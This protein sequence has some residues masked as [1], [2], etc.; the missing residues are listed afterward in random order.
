MADTAGMGRDLQRAIKLAE[1]LPNKNALFTAR[2]NYASIYSRNDPQRQV[3]VFRDLLDLAGDPTLVH[4]YKLYERTAF[5]FRNPRP[6]ILFQLMQVNLLLADYANAGRFA[7]ILYDTVVRP[8]PAAPQAPFFTAELAIVKAYQGDYTA[9]R[10]FLEES[11]KYFRRP[12]EKIPYPS[13]FLAAGM[14]DEHDGKD[15]Q[16]LGNYRKAYEMGGME[17]L[18]LEPSELY[19]AHAL[20]RMNR[21]AE[22][23]QVL[24]QVRAKLP[25]RTYTAYGYYYYQ[26]YAGLLRAKGDYIGYGK[27]LQQYYSIKDSLTNLNHY[28]AIEEIE[29]RVRLRDKEQ[30]IVRLNEEQL[31]RARRQ[32]EERIYFS[33]LFGLLLFLMVLL[34]GYLRNRMAGMRKQHRIDVMQGAMDAEQRERHKIA[35]QLHDEVGGLLSLAALNLSSALEGNPLEKRSQQQLQKAR[36]VVQA[37]GTTVRELSHRLTPLIIEKYGF[38]HAVEDLVETVNLSG[39][40]RLQLVMVGFGEG[41]VVGGSLRNEVYRTVQELVQ[42]VVRHAQATEALLQLVEHPDRISVMIEDN[43]IGIGEGELGSGKGLDTIRKKI[44]YF[45]GYL[46]ISSQPGKGALIVI[47]LPVENT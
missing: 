47:E 2:Y 34:I 17:G 14:I 24:D 5:C 7:D 8:N 44:A 23:A 26:Q 6:S 33:V 41:S 39:K 37:V 15:E 9:A 10:Q 11:R 18:H 35:D 28:R 30:Q 13:Y 27:A 22:A 25:V 32:R 46:E 42:N 20:I 40:L 36:E 21:L 16:A 29:A 38:R 12:E 45:N 43:G 3:S 31:A 1:E 19:Y 4:K